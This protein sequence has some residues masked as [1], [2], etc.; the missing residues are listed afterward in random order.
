MANETYDVIVIGLGVVGAAAAYHLAGSGLRVLG[1]EQFPINHDKGS[2]YGESRIIRYAYQDAVY[3]EMAKQAFPLWRAL[4]AENAYHLLTVTGGLDFGAAQNAALRATRSQLTAA[5]IAHEWLTPGETARRF[6][7]FRLDDDMMAVYQPDAGALN[8]SACVVALVAEAQKRGAV[9]CDNTPAYHIDVQTDS[10]VVHSAR[11]THSAGRVVLAAGAWMG[12]LLRALDLGLP[13]LPTR[14]EQVFFE[15]HNNPDFQAGRFPVFIQHGATVYYG[16][17]DAGT[18][19][20]VGIHGRSQHVDPDHVTR[21][22][23]PAYAQKVRNWTGRYIPSGAGG[24]RETRVCL[25][26][27]T[28]DEHFIID[29]HPA[30]KHVVIGSACSGHGFKFG[31]LTGKMLAGLAQGER[32]NH[33]LFNL[34]RF[35]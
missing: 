9:L 20:K 22:A 14:E 32:L 27:M 35:L 4:E 6:P 7:Q 34:R 23:D 15:T 11:G 25:Y 31:I 19:L 28:P 17:P 33:D 12:K 21:E 29:T 5:G 18:G 26:T 3:V 30:H 2:S 16:L 24:V 13:L 10:V 1:L 8:A